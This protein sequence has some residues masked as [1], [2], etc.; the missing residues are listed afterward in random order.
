MTN[1]KLQ[2]DQL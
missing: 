1:I 2:M